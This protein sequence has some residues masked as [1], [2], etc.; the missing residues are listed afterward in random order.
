MTTQ[1]SALPDDVRALMAEKEKAIIAKTLHP[2][3][4]P[5]KDQSGRERLAAGVAMPDAELRGIDWLVEGAQGK[6]P[7]G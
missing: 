3:T 7:S 1:N 5:I 6:L 4:G 2:F